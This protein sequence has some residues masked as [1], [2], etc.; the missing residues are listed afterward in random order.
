MYDWASAIGEALLMAYRVKGG[1][2]IMI[3]KDIARNRDMVIKTYLWG[4]GIRH[5][6]YALDEEGYL[7]TRMLDRVLREEKVAGIYVEYPNVYGYVPM[8]FDEFIEVA[9]K[10]GVLVIMGVDPFSLIILKPP[11]EYG[12]DIVVG[13]GQA[14]GGSMNYGGPLLGIFAV[15]GDMAL[16]R[17]MP[18]RIIGISRDMDGNRAYTMI[19]QTREQHIRREKATSNICTNEALTAI[20]VA[21][22]ISLLGKDGLLRLAK[23]LLEKSHKLCSML[24]DIG[25]KQLFNQPYIREFSLIKDRPYNSSYLYKK[26]LDIGYVFGWFDNNVHHI[27]VNEYHSFEDYELLIKDIKV[28]LN[29]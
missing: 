9:H 13:E 21:I 3:P 2:I 27:A 14:L 15:R 18:G 16:I 5:L 25:F 20:S 12:A 19:L 1:G 4:A 11:G 28:I 22:Y 26:L 24:E 29:G 8:N 10:Y 7:P 17:N 23:S 6:G